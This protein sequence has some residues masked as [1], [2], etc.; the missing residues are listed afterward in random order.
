MPV[1]S[2]STAEEVAATRKAAANAGLVGGGFNGP[3][4][5]EWCVAGKELDKINTNV[6]STLT[7]V[8]GILDKL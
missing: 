5:V 6:R 3:L 4:Y 2:D 7:F 8:E 1:Q